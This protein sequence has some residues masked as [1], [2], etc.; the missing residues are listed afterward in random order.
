MFS[1]FIDSIY[2]RNNVHRIHIRQILVVVISKMS[3]NKIFHN[4]FIDS[5][6]LNLHT[7]WTIVRNYCHTLMTVVFAQICEYNEMQ[8]IFL[9]VYIEM[10]SVDGTSYNIC[11]NCYHTYN[12]GK[13]SKVHCEERCYYYAKDA[14]QFNQTSRC[15]VCRVY[16]TKMVGKS[17][18]HFCFGV[19][20]QRQLIVATFGRS[21]IPEAVSI[22]Y[23][24]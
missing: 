11:V 19:N 5:K 12:R 16:Y 17:Y 14:Q 4:N 7:N 24:Y 9:S 22:A 15:A 1:L 2:N 21:R 10:P 20:E 18:H 3:A 6:D 13:P 8:F 23:H